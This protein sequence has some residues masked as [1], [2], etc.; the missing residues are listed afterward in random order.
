M[1]ATTF[2]FFLSLFL[3]SSS[4]VEAGAGILLPPPEQRIFYFEPNQHFEWTWHAH[5]APSLSIYL[6]GDLEEYG[7]LYDDDPL[8]PERDFTFTLDLPQELEPG[9]H[10][11]LAY[12]EEARPGG[13]MIG[14][15]A[16]V[17]GRITIIS[18]FPGPYA[19]ASLEV[20]DIGEY[21]N[22][23]ADLLL[24]SWS[25]DVMNVYA[26]LTVTDSQGEVVLVKDTQI[27]TL[28]P[29]EQK[30]LSTTLLTHDLPPGNYLVSAEI[31]G[32]Q[33]DLVVSDA[34][35]IGTFNVEVSSYT[36]Q[37]KTATVNRFFFTLKSNWNEPIGDVRG[38]LSLLN[39]TEVSP[40]I[41]LERFGTS[42]LSTFIDLTDITQDQIAQGTLTIYYAGGSTQ[43]PIKVNVS[44]PLVP[45]EEKAGFVFELNQLTG[46][47]I[48]LILLVLVN[49]VLLLRK[50]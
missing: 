33:A 26:T 15:V 47:Y 11:L 17:A 30:T 44:T 29:K 22:A 13:A 34:F 9:K 1:R 31:K 48:L 43:F 50:K 14:G 32:A 40:S 45:E 4:F 8:G 46:L 3:L 49:V 36:T 18:L 28:E 35:L 19:D 5:R 39:R 42:E 27:A 2:F 16:R 6:G 20:Y 21:G 24:T 10:E 23:T 38:E 25:K 7:T 37:L 12:V 41:Q